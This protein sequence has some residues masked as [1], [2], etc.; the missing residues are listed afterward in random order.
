MN[1]KRSN[2]FY[3]KSVKNDYLNNKNLLSRMHY[4]WCKIDSYD[5][6]PIKIVMSRRGLGK[7]FGKVLESLNKYAEDNLQ[8]IYVVETLEMVKTLSQDAGFKFFKAINEFL[9]ERPKYRKGVL[10]KML[11]EASVTEDSD[12]KLENGAVV[13]GG[14][15]RIMGKVAGYILALNDFANLKR[16]NFP[17]KLS[18][19]IIDEFIS[20]KTDISI[21]DNPR[22]LISILGSVARNREVK[23]YMLS[24]TV[25]SRDPI[26]N[27]L[28]IQDMI[29]GEIRI[30]NDKYGPLIIAHR[31]AL[32]EYPKFAEKQDSSV[33]GRLSALM[34]EDNLE[35]NVFED[36]LKECLRIPA[37]RKQSH[38]E[39]CLHGEL[40]SVRIHV[41]Q[42]RS[43]FYCI[44]DY[45]SNTK[46]RYC[47]KEKYQNHTVRFRPELRDYFITLYNK[48]MILFDTELN[49]LIFKN[50]LGLSMK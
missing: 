21:L 41:T 29:P 1:N 7:T 26:L 8:F 4:E 50:I 30:I 24:N 11:C 45:G 43:N 20:E 48:K 38:M 14:S 18:L 5:N 40:G 32:E 49:H 6:I 39:Y 36:D 17:K 10:G 33:V 3:F 34:G 9:E 16:N 44:D 19:I 47:I 37:V 28:K 46:N 25:S 13:K 35:K 27:R 42:D 23:I 31:V 12:I 2:L 22:K 15:I